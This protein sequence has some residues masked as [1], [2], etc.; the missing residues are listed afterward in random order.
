MLS[1]RSL[2]GLRHALLLVLT[3]FA[4]QAAEAYPLSVYYD[5]LHSGFVDWSWAD[6][7][8]AQQKVVHTGTS[9]ISFEPDAWKALFLH[10]N[11]TLN[12]ADY[13]AIEIWIH[14]GPNGGQRLRVRGALGGDPLGVGAPLTDFLPGGVLPPG[15]WVRVQIPLVN[16]GLISGTFDGIWLQDDTGGD[17]DAVF[18]DDVELLS[19][20]PNSVYDDQ[21]RNGFVDWSWAPVSYTQSSVVHTGPYAISFTPE[22]WEALF[23]HR[24]AGISRTDFVGVSFCIHGGTTG[25][26]KLRLALLDVGTQV[27]NAPLDGFIP[28]GSIPAN[29]WV[30][31]SVPFSALL[32][33]S[34]PRFDGIWLQGDLPWDQST[35]YVDD[36]Q[37]LPAAA[38]PIQVTIS[39]EAPRHAISPLIYGVNFNSFDPVARLRWPVRRWGGNATTRYSWE[40]DVANRAHD[41]FFANIA[42]PNPNPG[43]LPDGSLA[44]RFIDETRALGGEVLLTM[45]TIGWTPIDRQTR[46]GFS[47]DKY[48]SQ[49]SVDCT[50]LPGGKCAGNGIGLN[51]LPITGND[52]H[53]TSREVGPTFDMSWMAHIA[54]RVGTAAQGGVRFFALDNE[55]ILWNSSHRDVHPA[56]VTYDELWQ[57]TFNY[58]SAIKAM[59]SK[60][61]V[62]GPVTWGWCDLFGSA[63]DSCANG[64][65]RDSHGGMPLLEWYLQQV[66][67]NE[68]STGV[69]LVDWVDIHYYPQ[70]PA[71]TLSDNELPTVAAR[72]LRSLQSLYDPSYVDE[73]W[74]EQPVNLIPRVKGWIANRLPGAKLAITE[75]NWGND[76][77]L[78]SALAQ[79]E[80]LAIFGRE[81]VDLATRW[82]APQADSLVEKSF[83]FYLDYDGQGSRVTGDSIK[84]VSSRPGT[85]GAYTIWDTN[86]SLTKKIYVLLFNKDENPRHVDV[87]LTS[88]APRGTQPA[89]YRLDAAGL[90]PVNQTVSL[91]SQGFGIDLPARSAT[92]VILPLG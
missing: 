35:V 74:I 21:L 41:W 7:D 9:A 20:F 89:L 27:A 13:R 52:P 4:T 43:L 14:G 19:P 49:Q 37:L 65:D 92:M 72:R 33:S 50:I 73:S 51:G 83:R 56:P 30:C 3:I 25:R 86:V 16:I 87:Q 82:L 80:A 60:A 2:K 18:V 47:V 6:H 28:G 78:T 57:N 68:R 8:L 36:V 31:F 34:N 26:Q 85:V 55:P 90:N 84:T 39:P 61:E 71:V 64:P 45:P 91:T 79:A 75:Y 24:D 10:R 5:Q 40:D 63:A 53:D 62:F 66:Q 29:Q 88:Q 67:N 70:A 11:G 22:A 32:P 77:G 12:T 44:D 54:S 76:N 81:G 58:A 1:S 42:E 15:Q 48:G 23:F 59:D 69:R 46:V 38:G 17:Q